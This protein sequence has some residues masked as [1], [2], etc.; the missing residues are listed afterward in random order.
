MDFRKYPSVLSPVEHEVVGGYHGLNPFCIFVV[1][2][3]VY[4]DLDAGIG[5]LHNVLVSA[6]ERVAG[7]VLRG[8]LVAVVTHC[9]SSQCLVSRP[10]NGSISREIESHEAL[11]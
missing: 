7:S 8:K 5:D 10:G 2:V 11:E 9:P 6:E 3:V 1:L 4:F